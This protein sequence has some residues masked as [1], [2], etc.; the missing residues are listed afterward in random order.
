MSTLWMG[1]KVVW[2]TATLVCMEGVLAGLK[3]LDGETK[4]LPRKKLLP[5]DNKHQEP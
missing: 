3:A 4:T 5:L 2:T 1:V